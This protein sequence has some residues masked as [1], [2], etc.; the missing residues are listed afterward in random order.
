MLTNKDQK[1][2]KSITLNR[3]FAV[4]SVILLVS[5]VWMFADDYERSWKHYQK[6]FRKIQSEKLAVGYDSDEY[7]SGLYDAYLEK[8]KIRAAEEY[9]EAKEDLKAANDAF[10]VVDQDYK[11]AKAELNKLTYEYK[12]AQVGNGGDADELRKKLAADTEKVRQKKLEQEKL[13][14]R[15]REQEKRLQELR[16]QEKDIDKRFEEQFGKEKVLLARQHEKVEV[17]R[18][19][20]AN[21]IADAVRDLPILDLTNPYYRIQQVVVNDVTEDMNFVKVPKVDRCVSCHQGM[22]KPEFVNEP[23]PYNAHPNLDLFVSSSSPHAYE[24]FGCTSCHAGRGRGTSFVSTVHMPSTHQQDLKWHH[25]EIGSG[26]V[27]E[28]DWH[29]M[30]HWPR[31]MYPKKYTEAGCFKCHSEATN[32]EGADK[33][34]LGLALIE[35]SGCYGCHAIEKYRP[36]M[37][38]NNIGPSLRKVASK[39]K[40]RDWAKKWIK[41][42]RDFRHNSW[43]PSFYGSGDSDPTDGV[44]LLLNHRYQSDTKQAES[45]IRND[46]EIQAMTHYIFEQSLD[47]KLGEIPKSGN[48]DTGKNLFGA[49]GCQGCHQVAPEPTKEAENIADKRNQIRKEYGPNLIGIGTKASAEWIYS[50][51]KNPQ[52]YNPNTMM[53][54]LRLTNQEAADLTEYLLSLNQKGFD[55]TTVAD[56][57]TA[58]LDTIAGEFLQGSYT[59]DEITTQLASWN[60]ED[61]L[62]Y[63]GKKL[64]SHYGCY[65]CHEISGFEDAKPMGAELTYHGSKMVKKFDFGLVQS[66]YVDKKGKKKYKDHLPHTNSAWFTQKL[67]NPR[68]WG[69][70]ASVDLDTEKL[71]NLD[72]VHVVNEF[73]SFQEKYRMPNYGF[74]DMEIE[75][76]VT[77]LM[78]FVKQDAEASKIMP[79]TAKN[80]FHEKGQSII[81]EKNCQGCHLIE[82]R[83]HAIKTALFD[84]MMDQPDYEDLSRMEAKA[85][86]VSFIPPNLIGEGQKVQPDWLY[87]FFRAPEMVRPAVQIRMPTYNFTEEEI[88]ILIKYF[89]YLEPKGENFEWVD[90]DSWQNNVFR[91][92]HQISLSNKEYAEA[93]KLVSKDGHNCGQCHWMGNKE[94]QNKLPKD[95]A[96]NWSL[97]SQR[98]KPEWLAYWIAN[99]PGLMSGTKMPAYYEG[100]KDLMKDS[101]GYTNSTAFPEILG[102]DDGA[103]VRA[104]RDYVL[105]FS[106]NQ[107]VQQLPDAETQAIKKYVLNTE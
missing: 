60:E 7:D 28:K 38:K 57:D 55:Q 102:G 95:Q 20:F 107:V 80:V 59:R 14:V 24:A 50:W 49:L 40:D 37:E 46:T 98:L 45:G 100:Y 52:E 74:T 85:D 42:P 33:L 65:G 16:A 84:W 69:T 12:E 92:P 34:N 96:P 81:A 73:K 21:K 47:F 27:K 29:Q 75:A 103:Q 53:P 106:A 66:E 58:M 63:T 44:G 62:S 3:I 8:E 99:A 68:I 104:L 19:S 22:D 48:K 83:G 51:I 97:A 82:G 71:T 77:A 86:L 5:L 23:P 17:A 30:H 90:V 101:E 39:L 67:K 11:F 36:R 25:G 78:G 32:L 9:N 54:N 4:T 89:N 88:N 105:N 10:Y 13:D 18:M 76:I 91:D 61:K 43:M 87:H 56:Y 72:S 26:D 1:Y 79:R 15:L 2:Y 31:P 70:N 93:E 94:P 6:N 64:I 35:K 41:N